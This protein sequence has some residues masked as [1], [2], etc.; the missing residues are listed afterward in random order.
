MVRRP[1]RSTRVRS[2]AA[3]DVYKRQGSRMPATHATVDQRLHYLK[4][5]GSEVFRFA[6]RVVVE[7]ALR[8][9][10]SCGRRV[11]EVRLFIPHQANLRIIEAATRRLGIP[12]DRVY[13]NLQRYGNTSCAS[14]PLC[15]H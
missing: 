13:T 12:D 10:E 7:S 1:P 8:V 3:S 14:I 5:S 15:L 9:L 6:T 2:S 11:G 4:M